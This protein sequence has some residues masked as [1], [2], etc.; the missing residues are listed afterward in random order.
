MANTAKAWKDFLPNLE[1][2]WKV[3]GKKSIKWSGNSTMMQM[4]DFLNILQLLI[5]KLG[6]TER[7]N[8]KIPS[9]EEVLTEVFYYAQKK[10]QKW[11]FGPFGKLY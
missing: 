2:S 9:F 4:V 3:G 10:G 11:D 8:K 7:K 1:K 5:V 6:K